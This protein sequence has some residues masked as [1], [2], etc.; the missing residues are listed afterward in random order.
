MIKIFKKFLIL[1]ILILSVTF[2]FSKD[3]PKKNFLV[4]MSFHPILPWSMGMVSEMKELSEKNNIKFHIEYLDKIRTNN[5]LTKDEWINYLKRKYKLVKFDAILLDGEYSSNLFSRIEK[6]VSKNIPILH[7]IASK[8]NLKKNSYT[9]SKENGNKV[10]LDTIDMMLRHHPDLET[11][12]LIKGQLSYFTLSEHT[13]LEKLKKTNVKVVLLK[14]YTFAELYLKV[15]TL[16]KN[17]AIFYN[18]TFKDKKGDRTSPF[19][20]VENIN[21]NSNVPIYANLQTLT[22]K[23]IVGGNLVSAEESI[24]SMVEASLDFI[25]YKEFKKEYKYSE[26]IVD[27]NIIKKFNID[28]SL[29]DAKTKIINKPKSIFETH[30]YEVVTGII[31]ISLLLFLLLISL[32]SSSKLK[33]LNKKLKKETKNRLE[34]EKMLSKQSRM[35]AMGEMINNIAHQW[36]QP[37]NRIN[38]NLAVIN[39]LC[40][41]YRNK[42]KLLNEKIDNIK[43]QTEYMS[44]TIEDFLS[45]FHPKKQLDSF[46]ILKTVENTK[47]LI[48]SR[49]KNIEFNLEYEDLDDVK[50]YSYEGEFIQV[51]LSILN[52]SIDN[53]EI[54]NIKE[55]KIVIQIKEKTEYIILRIIDNGG[56]IEKKVLEKIFDPY[57]TTKGGVESSGLGLYISKMI[58]ENS[59]KGSI[60]VFSYDDKTCFNIKIKKRFDNDKI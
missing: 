58:I 23:G 60:K 28:E 45:F 5:L 31:I 48:S 22:N 47:K 40:D 21:K 49:L 55:A 10:H 54:K 18:V 44:N 46:F 35:A 12:Y 51:L 14:D 38:S 4:L 1:L 16:P 9:L 50:I 43:N 59:M 27:W 36:R 57:F 6:N 33:I 42:E 11:I 7:V 19:R 25:K 52:N 41:K 37:L 13:L 56:G 32:W 34:K 8:K 30:F 26:A 53:F 17:S 15:K 29:I 39:I 3:L 2:S 20:I 24:K